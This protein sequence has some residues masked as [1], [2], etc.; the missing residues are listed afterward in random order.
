MNVYSIATQLTETDYF[1]GFDVIN[2]GTTSEETRIWLNDETFIT[3]A[4]EEDS[5]GSYLLWSAYE[6]DGDYF[7]LLGDNGNYLADAIA[8]IIAWAEANK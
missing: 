8:D 1:T 2:G 4:I 3:I 7:G 5:E 6:T